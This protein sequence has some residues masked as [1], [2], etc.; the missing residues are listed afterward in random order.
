MP[1]LA[2][3]F[4]LVDVLVDELRERTARFH[5]VGTGA[6]HERQVDVADRSATDPR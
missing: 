4:R 1:A 6:P 2:R 5:G 3:S